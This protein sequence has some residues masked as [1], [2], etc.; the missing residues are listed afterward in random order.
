MELRSDFCQ[1]WP[2]IS[3]K[4]KVLRKVCLL[5]IHHA[6]IQGLLSCAH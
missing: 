5:Q 3:T 2:C 1:Q 6:C 4:R